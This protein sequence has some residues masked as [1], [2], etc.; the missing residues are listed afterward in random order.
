MNKIRLILTFFYA[1]YF[2]VDVIHLIM[3]RLGDSSGELIREFNFETTLESLLKLGLS[4]IAIF[5]LVKL[6]NNVK[7][8]SSLLLLISISIIVYF[9]LN[10]TWVKLTAGSLVHN[11]N[12]IYVL[13]LATLI[14]SVIY[15]T[16]KKE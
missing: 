16:R 14:F 3:Y 10:G 5:S 9:F 4:V 13:G 11:I 1:I 8:Y 15:L 2:I 6:N 7:I 12:L